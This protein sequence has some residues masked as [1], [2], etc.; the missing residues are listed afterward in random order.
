MAACTHSKLSK[1]IS[2]RIA[3]PTIKVELEM[4]ILWLGMIVFVTFLSIAKSG[5]GLLDF[6]KLPSIT[7]SVRMML[8]SQFTVCFFDFVV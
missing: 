5:V 3:T 1:D 6:L 8:H 2:K 7:A 4:L